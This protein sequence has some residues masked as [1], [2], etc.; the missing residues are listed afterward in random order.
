MPTLETSQQQQKQLQKADQKLCKC[1]GI[2]MPTFA[3]PHKQ[4]TLLLTCHTNDINLLRWTGE[5]L[6]FTVCPSPQFDALQALLFSGLTAVGQQCLHCDEHNFSKTEN[7][8]HSVKYYLTPSQIA[9]W[10][11]FGATSPMIMSPVPATM[12]SIALDLGQLCGHS[13]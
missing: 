5:R 3:T 11:M 4:Q 13:R 10:P 9:A 8:N 12:K 6:S 2:K 1:L 7:R